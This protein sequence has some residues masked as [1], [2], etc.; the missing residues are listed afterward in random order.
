MNTFLH[1]TSA[2]GLSRLTDPI[3]H[4]K[5]FWGGICLG[6]YLSMIWACIVIFQKYVDPNNIITTV[7]TE[8]LKS[9]MFLESNSSR[10]P[11]YPRIVLC[12]ED[13]FLNF[14]QLAEYEK[15]VLS[16]GMNKKMVTGN[17]PPLHPKILEDG[18]MAMCTMIPSGTASVHI[19]WQGVRKRLRLYFAID[20][21]EPYV[22]THDHEGERI[23]IVAE[24]KIKQIY[25]QIRKVVKW[26]YY[27]GRNSIFSH[28]YPSRMAEISVSRG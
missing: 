9:D 18:E 16:Y 8:S 4:R 24:E 13:P 28:G 5:I 21:D 6:A 2:H 15:I 11:Y 25:I 27:A 17:L 22:L 20:P 23:D 26:K 3:G 7:R 1:S 10:T 14:V 12:A 19:A